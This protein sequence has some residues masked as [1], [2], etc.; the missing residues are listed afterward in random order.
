[1]TI[2][3]GLRKN[4]VVMAIILNLVAPAGADERPLR[5]G[6]EVTRPER[7]SGPPPLYAELARRARVQGVVIVEATIDT[8][9]NVVDFARA[10]GIADGA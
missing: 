10:E 3:P 6:G 5:V 7:I 1:M 8:Q 9:G 2:C 4:V